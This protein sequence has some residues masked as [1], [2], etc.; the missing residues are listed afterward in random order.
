MKLLFSVFCDEV[1][2]SPKVSKVLREHEIDT[3]NEEETK[4]FFAQSVHSPYLFNSVRLESDFKQADAIFFD[5]DEGGLE[6]F[7]NSVIASYSHILYGSRNHKI[8]K[9]S[10]EGVKPPCDRFH[11]I[12]KL[13]KTYK[14]VAEIKYF[15][16]QISNVFKSLNIKPDKT[17][18]AARFIFPSRLDGQTEPNPFFN[19]SYTVVESQFFIDTDVDTL[20]E[21]FVFKS[22]ALKKDPFLSIENIE[23]IEN[24][25]NKEDLMQELTD[26]AMEFI[27]DMPKKYEPNRKYDLDGVKWVDGGSFNHME[28]MTLFFAIFNSYDTYTAENHCLRISNNQSSVNAINQMKNKSINH[29][30]TNKTIIK[31]ATIN[32]FKIPSYLQDQMNHTSNALIKDKIKQIFSKKK[33]IDQLFDEKNKLYSEQGEILNVIEQSKTTLEI[34]KTTIEQYKSTIDELKTKKNELNEYSANIEGIDSEA[35]KIRIKSLYKQE[36]KE[37]KQYMEEQI[38]K[39]KEQIKEIVKETET[40]EEEDKKLKKASKEIDKKII[41]IDKKITETESSIK[42]TE[43]YIEKIKDSNLCATKPVDSQNQ[44]ATTIPFDSVDFM[45]FFNSFCRKF[46][47]NYYVVYKKRVECYKLNGLI[48]ATSHLQTPVEEDGKVKMVSSAF[49]WSRSYG[50]KVCE[51]ELKVDYV[52]DGPVWLDDSTVNLFTTPYRVVPTLKTTLFP[53]THDDGTVEQMTPFDILYNVLYKSLCNERKD[54][55]EFVIKW[56]AAVA[57]YGRTLVSLDINGEEGTGKSTV[58]KVL[59]SIMNTDRAFITGNIDDVMGAFNPKMAGCFLLGLEE[60]IDLRDKDADGICKY[61]I[62]GDSVVI[63][64]KFKNQVEYVNHINLIILS[65]NKFSSRKVSSSN[66]RDFIL[67]TSEKYAEKVN[68]VTNPLNTRLFDNLYAYVK[69]EHERYSSLTTIKDEFM[70]QLLGQFLTI[71]IEDDW[72][73]KNI[74][75]TEEKIINKTHS[76]TKVEQFMFDLYS[77]KGYLE[78]Y[79]TDNNKLEKDEP[80]NKP[81]RFTLWYNLFKMHKKNNSS[82]SETE[83]KYELKKFTTEHASVLDRY[84]GSPRHSTGYAINNE[85]VE[86]YFKTK[87]ANIEL[88]DTVIYTDPL[89][90]VSPTQQE[91]IAQLCST[92]VF[93]RK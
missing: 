54:V 22:I 17:T 24:N 68:G 18:D 92:D 74:F 70:G 48:D 23:N 93:N 77:Y 16:I 56:M 38:N 34:N 33:E 37:Q 12:F 59:R 85:K 13:S 27:C 89:K 31:F 45:P 80:L 88:S 25:E 9:I 36:I 84:T 87:G 49:L 3:T 86:T 26:L 50:A 53:F 28:R 19:E 40:T 15:T 65:N 4:S 21:N 8:E 29:T 5:F 66:R 11:V 51:T 43:Q 44:Y 6:I 10:K 81:I 75:D 2:Y 46:G 83:F 32:G 73:R 67:T 35:D 20:T 42:L 52:V 64:K 41:E 61:L 57:Q 90:I 76:F 47:D 55:T 71:E 91:P 60:A 58:L 63:N 79:P 78:I 62:N 7:K 30:V 72:F 69:T 1:N 14:T 39:T 82:V